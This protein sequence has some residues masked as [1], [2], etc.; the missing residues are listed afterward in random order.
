MLKP[1]AVEGDISV[2]ISDLDIFVATYGSSREFPAPPYNPNMDWNLSGDIVNDD[3]DEFVQR[4][5]SEWAF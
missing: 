3:L 4:Y 1:A 2:E 5:G